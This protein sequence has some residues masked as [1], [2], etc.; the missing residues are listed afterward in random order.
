MVTPPIPWAACSNAWPLPVK[1][2]LISNL[3]LPWCNLRLLSHPITSYLGEETET[4]LTT[5]AFQVVVEQTVRSPPS[6]PFSRPNHT[7]S[8]SLLHKHP[9]NPV[10]GLWYTKLSRIPEH[11]KLQSFQQH[12]IVFPSHQN[13]LFCLRTDYYFPSFFILSLHYNLINTWPLFPCNQLHQ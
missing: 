12:L 13:Y 6:L 1:K 5:T 11:R 2:F 8:L 3:N 10:G 4:C 7:S 9:P